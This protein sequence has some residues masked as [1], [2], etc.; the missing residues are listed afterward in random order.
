MLPGHHG[1]FGLRISRV[2][3]RMK[4]NEPRNPTSTRKSAWRLCS[5]SWSCQK[6]VKIEAPT[7]TADG[8]IG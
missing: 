6:S 3:M 2:L 8:S 7:A 4:T 1:T 5:T